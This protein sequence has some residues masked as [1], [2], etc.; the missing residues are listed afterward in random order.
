[1]DS[2][3]LAYRLLVCD[4]SRGTNLSI[5]AHCWHAGKSRRLARELVYDRLK[6]CL[7]DQEMPVELTSGTGIWID[8][9]PGICG[10]RY[11]TASSRTR[12]TVSMD[13]D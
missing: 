4:K 12:R 7:G 9:G 10:G 6:M 3:I 11:G 1:M 2:W 13:R 8:E 5:A